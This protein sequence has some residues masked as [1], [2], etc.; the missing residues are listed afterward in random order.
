[1]PA[2]CYAC[3]T[4]LDLRCI[5]A[6]E[7]ARRAI[8]ELLFFSRRVTAMSGLINVGFVICSV[9]FILRLY[10]QR[11]CMH[12]EEQDDFDVGCSDLIRMTFLRNIQYRVSIDADV[13]LWLDKRSFDEQP[14]FI[15]CC[16][17]T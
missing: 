12:G 6:K 9:C 3:R 13:A 11:A 14:Q 4:I 16:I 7:F 10:Q 17:T 15:S 8:L 5:S 1:M 2:P